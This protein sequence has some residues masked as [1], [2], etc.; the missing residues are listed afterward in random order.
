MDTV[1]IAV[2]ALSISMATGMALVVAKLVREERARAE[3]RVAALSAMSA[4]PVDPFTGAAAPDRGRA[5]CLT[6]EAFGTG[7]AIG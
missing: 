4:D 2:T 1:L 6:I 3:A 7:R 5:G